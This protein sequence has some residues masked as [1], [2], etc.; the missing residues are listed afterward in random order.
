VPEEQTAFEAI[1][2]I[3]VEAKDLDL[4]GRGRKDE[5]CDQ[6]LFFR[7]RPDWGVS[8]SMAFEVE[9][10]DV[11]EG[12]GLPARGVEVLRLVEDV[13]GR[14]VLP[15][16]DRRGVLEDLEM[17]FVAFGGMPLGL[18]GEGFEVEGAAPEGTG[19][20]WR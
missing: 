13:G 7:L 19:T 1:L 10:G 16:R 15:L 2:V 20:R 5:R 17:P 8:W 4:G 14:E 11:L 18:G 3:H 12:E 6:S 9:L